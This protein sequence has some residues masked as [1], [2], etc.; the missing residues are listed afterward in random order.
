MTA[1]VGWISIR[2]LL[3]LVRVTG[4]DRSSPV[5][6]DANLAITAG[7]DVEL[8]FGLQE[9]AVVEERDPSD[10]SAARRS[11]TA[12]RRGRRPRSLRERGELIA[13]PVASR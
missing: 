9:E 6:H 4:C 3:S 7:V 2:A 11:R 12:R 10:P 13:E 8:S 5:E 1:R